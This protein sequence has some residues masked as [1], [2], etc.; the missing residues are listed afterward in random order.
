M[1][2][3]MLFL[4]F[5]GFLLAWEDLGVIGETYEIKEPDFFDEIAKNYQKLDKEKF[6]KELVDSIKE[7][8]VGH[9]PLPFCQKDTVRKT[10]WSVHNKAP[11][12][13]EIPQGD[14]SI[15][16]GQS[17]KKDFN[18]PDLIYEVINTDSHH[19]LLWLKTRKGM[20]PVM[21]NQGS[22]E[23][24]KK[25]PEKYLLS[26]FLKEKLNLQCTPSTVEFKGDMLIVHEHK[27]K[28]EKDKK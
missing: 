25:Y 9:V 27:I 10:D 14:I 7:A 3:L 6:K 28:R 8:L 18:M 16:A 15:K 23:K 21:V 5:S 19:E 4:M 22:V 2:K 20:P 12:D 11:F 1:K 26:D 24:L 13:L 17:P